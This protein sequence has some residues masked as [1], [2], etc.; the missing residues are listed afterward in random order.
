MNTGKISAITISLILLC[1]LA[2][3]VS[4]L[5][6]GPNKTETYSFNPGDNIDES[7]AW[8]DSIGLFNIVSASASVDASFYLGIDLPFEMEITY[9]EWLIKSTSFTTSVSAAGKTGG[10]CGLNIHA[11]IRITLSALSGLLSWDFID[12]SFNLDLLSE[13][14]TPIGSQ[15]SDLISDKIEL[16]SIHIPIVDYEIA[17]YF[18]AEAKVELAGSLQSDISITGNS[19][20]SNLHKTLKWDSTE[21]SHSQTSQTKSDATSSIQVGLDNIELSMTKLKITLT[22][23]FLEFT[24]TGHSPVRLNLDLPDFLSGT[25]PL[26]IKYSIGS[27][28]PLSIPLKVPESSDNP[29]IDMLSNNAGAIIGIGVIGAAVVVVAG[30]AKRRSS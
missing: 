19:L 28:N 22:A 9:P 21:A 5:E 18:G 3:P 4:S 11:G 26:N 16:G 23:F 27:T 17:A 7:G 8:S 6:L 30:I 29:V 12:K 24:A 1:I 25:A 2:V 15:T 20:I 13:F 14:V 10:K